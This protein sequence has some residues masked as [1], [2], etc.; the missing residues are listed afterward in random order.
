[1]IKIVKFKRLYPGAKLPRRWSSGA[2]GWD[3]HAYIVNEQ[4]RP[5]KTIIPPS[6]TVNIS[7]GLLVEPP[8][9]HCILITPRSGL[10]KKSISVTNSP[11]L[12]DPDYRGEIKVLVYNGGLQN[13]WLE[14][15][16]RIAQMF[17][18]P[19]VAM[20]IQEVTELSETQRGRDGFGSTGD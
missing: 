5:S 4:N 11:G 1:M 3:L 15:D 20:S 17:I 7:T 12:I 16:T 9:G 6:T 18:I 2:V 13:F 8:P 10:G 14:H 19:V